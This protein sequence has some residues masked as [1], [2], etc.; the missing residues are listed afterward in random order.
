[1]NL[2][3]SV[4]DSLTGRECRDKCMDRRWLRTEPCNILV[5]DLTCT[6]PVIQAFPS[7]HLDFQRPPILFPPQSR[8][9]PPHCSV[10]CLLTRSPTRSKGHKSSA[11]SPSRSCAALFPPFRVPGTNPTKGEI[12]HRVR[13]F[14]NAAKHKPI[15]CRDAA[16]ALR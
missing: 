12:I 13:R 14:V 3:C 6:Y 10:S 7:A 4:L 11:K 8:R 5:V 1:M 15:S 9:S 2:N 16:I